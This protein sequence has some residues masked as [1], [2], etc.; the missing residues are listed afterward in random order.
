MTERRNT[1][2]YFRQLFDETS[3]TYTYLLGDLTQHE[4]AL[5]DPV[6]E[7][8]AL[9]LALLDE[10]KL[11]LRAV[12]ETHVHADHI[13]GAAQLREQTGAQ[14]VVSI[15]GGAPCADIHLQGDEQLHFGAETIT[16]L[17][18]PGHTP[19]CTSYLWR[20][21]LFSG[22]ALL[23]GGCGRTDFQG[24]DAGV[25][26]DSITRKIWPL[27]GETLIYPG[28]DYHHRH[29][30]CVA[31]ER[32]SN[33]RLAGKSR[34]EFIA[35]MSKLNLPKPRLIDLAVPANQLCGQEEPHAA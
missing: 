22:D 16:V 6:R 34:D 32:E 14:T 26:H 4:A 24:G 5:I 8:V 3:S 25:L 33:P 18:T 30:S 15:H 7:H 27:A 10:Q 1:M 23:I 12:L 11:T 20:D 28:H 19:G 21:R 9:Y 2:I 35:I 29:V 13:T 31:Q 17:A